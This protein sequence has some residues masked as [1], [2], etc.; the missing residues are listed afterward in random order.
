MHYM[1]AIMN[2]DLVYWYLSNRGSNLSGGF[3]EFVDW[4][5]KLMPIPQVSEKEQKPFET[6][7]KELH[8]LAA[9]HLSI[10]QKFTSLLIEEFELEKLSAKLESWHELAF[11][12]FLK[13]L[14]KK[15][16]KLTGE[17]KEEWHERFNR[18]QAEVKAL[19]EAINSKEQQLNTLVNA[20]YGLTDEE[21][22]FYKATLAK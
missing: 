10:S 20:L 15:K 2:S 11:K 4:L 1:T 22:A 21:V 3:L 13:E 5:V 7:S 6:L 17:N 8:D 19:S 12:D 9:N 14:A 16:V 18:L